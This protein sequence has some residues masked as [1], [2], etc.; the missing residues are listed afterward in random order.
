V[1]T[2]ADGTEHYAKLEPVWDGLD[3]VGALICF[4][5]PANGDTASAL[6]ATRSSARSRTKFGW[7][8]LTETECSLAELVAEGLTNR[9][10]AARLFLS[11]HTVDSHL[12]HIFRKLNINSRVELAGIA[13]L[14]SAE[15]RSPLSVSI[16]GEAGR[17][18]HPSS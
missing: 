11:R 10:A 13:T 12:R 5:H 7:G 17:V 3:L 6:A 8:S 16:S 18:V 9:E 1:F 15:L 14:R 4:R 2:V